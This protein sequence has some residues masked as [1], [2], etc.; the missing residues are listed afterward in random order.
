LPICGRG[1][2]GST[3]S[4]ETSLAQRVISLASAGF[5]WSAKVVH[6]DE[7][8]IRQTVNVMAF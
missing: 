5:H 3:L 6:A 1:Y 2:S 8:M 7:P 4:A